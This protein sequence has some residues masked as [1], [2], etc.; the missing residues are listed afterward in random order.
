MARK[1]R[2]KRSLRVL[3]HDCA[4]IDIGASVHWV[5]IDPALDAQPTRPFGVDTGSLEEMADWLIERGVRQ[6]ALEST[7]VYWVP[8]FELLERRG[9]SVHLVDA[10]ATK[11]VSGRKSDVRDCEWIQQL[12]SCGLL[13]AAFR[14]ADA[15]CEL[16]ALVRLRSQLV[17]DGARAV[18]HMQKAL[19]QM[20]IQLTEVLSDIAGKTGLAILRA[21][22][23]GERDGSQLA[24]LRD[25]R[26]RADE[27]RLARSLTGNWRTEHVFALTLALQRYDFLQAQIADCEVAIDKA[28]IPLPRVAVVAI[29]PCKRLRSQ[30]RRDAAHN[31]QLRQAMHGLLGVDLTQIPTIALDTALI[32]CSEIGPDLSR[33]PDSPHF[34]AWLQLAPVVRIS[35]GKRLGGRPI[36]R[37]NR[38]GQALLQAAANARHSDSFIGASHRARLARMDK[39]TA[40]KATA[41][42]L[43]RLIYA[44]LTQ[45]QEYVERGIAGYEA[46]HKARQLAALKRKA[47]QLGLEIGPI[48]TAA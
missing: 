28:L 46:E 31:E 13:R 16:R 5:A 48:K 19:V 18:Q 39:P 30:H 12:M 17:R 44:S 43:A 9:L 8:V 41:H 40:I 32:V 10:R 3:Y 23:A 22:V 20:N 34:C 47:H 45:G 7:G 37:F 24:T 42:Q 14:P 35:G 2:Q 38:V 1:Q 27:A 4:G 29:P 15:I 21:I 11:Q 6:V 36:R 26:V 33:F 25:R